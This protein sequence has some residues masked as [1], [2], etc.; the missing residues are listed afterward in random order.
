M[1][2]GAILNGRDKIRKVL[3]NFI[4]KGGSQEQI[5]NSYYSTLIENLDCDKTIHKAVEVTSGSKLFYQ[6][7]EN[8]KIDN[9]IVQEMN[10]LPD[11]V[12]FIPIN[13]LMYKKYPETNDAIS[14]INKNYDTKNKMKLLSK[15]DSRFPMEKL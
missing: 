11:E 9:I 2:N 3:Q 4:D 15:K 7:A 5:A 13:I 8:D 10:Q 12:T 14:M 1:T 6:I